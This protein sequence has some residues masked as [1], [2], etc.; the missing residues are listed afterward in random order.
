MLQIC[1]AREKIRN[2]GR[3][4]PG[5]C[6]DVHDGIDVRQVHLVVHVAFQLRL[7]IFV[8]KVPELLQTKR[9]LQENRQSR[10]SEG[11]AFLE[12]V[13]FCKMC[14]LLIAKKKILLLACWPLLV[15]RRLQ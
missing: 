5:E 9:R 10:A 13:K 1:A 7:E 15:R 12:T 11:D 14:S 3:K 8:L 2:V 4:K 6:A